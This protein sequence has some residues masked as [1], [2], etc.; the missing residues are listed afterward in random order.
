MINAVDA[1]LL[2]WW[3]TLAVAILVVLREDRRP[4][5]RRSTLQQWADLAQAILVLALPA[6]WLLATNRSTKLTDQ[7]IMTV[8]VAAMGYGAAGSV[9]DRIRGTQRGGSK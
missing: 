9:R 8:I 4:R 6:F 3:W 5:E 2:G 1:V 7:L